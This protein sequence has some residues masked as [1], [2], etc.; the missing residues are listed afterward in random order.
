[1]LALGG[2]SALRHNVVVQEPDSGARARVRV[3]VPDVSY[4]G[5]RAYPNSTCVSKNVPGNGMVTSVQMVLGFEKNLNGKQ[6][7]IPESPSVPM[8]HMVSAEVY[9]R[10]GKPIAFSFLKPSSQSGTGSYVR[11]LADGCALGMSFIPEADKDY[12]LVF[13]EADRC[14]VIATELMTKGG[15]VIESPVAF[16]QAD[17]CRD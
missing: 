6:L 1:M 15:R 4:R 9:A 7:G 8:G 2:C 10:A 13:G 16:Q 11:V 5:V 3:S 17:T 12:V 14:D